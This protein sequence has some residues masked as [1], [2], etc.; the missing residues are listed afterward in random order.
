MTGL[1]RSM[2]VWGWRPVGD[3]GDGG[4]GRVAGRQGSP[5]RDAGEIRPLAHGAVELL[6]RADFDAL[7]EAAAARNRWQF[8][9]TIGLLPIPN[10]TGSRSTRSPSSS[11]PWET[12]RL[13]RG[14]PQGLT[15]PGM[16]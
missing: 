3:R 6:D 11:S 2:F 15:V 14:G 10:G 1:S 12:P 7:G 16:K 4:N 8:M 9:L 13:C 5:V